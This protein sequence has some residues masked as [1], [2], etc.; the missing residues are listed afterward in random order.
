MFCK[1]SLRLTLLAFRT[2]NT[3]SSE[4][5][6]IILRC[7]C[8]EDDKGDEIIMVFVKHEFK[9]IGIG[10]IIFLLLIVRVKLSILNW[11]FYSIFFIIDC[12]N[13]MACREHN[14]MPWGKNW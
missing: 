12:Y 11:R 7:S 10:Q 8:G 6:G 3:L 9:M 14:T 5:S 1:G 13:S 2:V 4:Y